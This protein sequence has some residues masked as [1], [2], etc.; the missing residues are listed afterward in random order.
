MTLDQYELCPCGSG[1]KIKFCCSRDLLHELD[2]LQTMIRG[3][4]RLAALEKID[5]LL[6][7]NPDRPS[8]LMLKVDLEL[9]LREADKARATLAKLLEVQPTNPSVV[10]TRSM[11]VLMLDRDIATAIHALQDSFELIDGTVTAR[12]Y[13]ALML[14]GTMLLSR[15]S[16]FAAKGH[17][18]F[19]LA[20]TD[21]KDERSA[22]S[23]M[24]LNQD[25]RIPLLLREPLSLEPC[26]A[27]VTWRIEFEKAMNEVGRGRW[28][29]GGKMLSA[30]ATRILDAPAILMNLGIVSGWLGDYDQASK[31]FRAYSQIREVPMERRVHA[32]ALAQELDPNSVPRVSLVQQT[33]ELE[34][35]DG[36]LEKCSSCNRLVS[37]P[38]DGN[39]SASDGG[40]P[41]KAIYRVLSKPALADGANDALDADP[42]LDQVPELLG[43]IIFFG[44]ETDQ[45]ARLII[46]ASRTHLDYITNLCQELVEKPLG[47]PTSDRP[48][49]GTP[50][51]ITELLG[52]WHL[53]KMKTYDRHQQLQRK[54]Q[55]K[56]VTERWPK[57]VM[58]FLD[59]KT[60]VDA[61][62]EAK[63]AVPLLGNLMTVGLTCDSLGVPFDVDAMRRQLNLPE[64]PPPS[65]QPGN[66]DRVPV[67]RFGE[68]DI[69]SLDDEQLLAAYRRSYALMVIKALR[70]TAREV[71]QRTSL[72]E[73][74]DKVEAYDILSDVAETT[75]ESLQYLSQAR[76]LATKEGES[77]AAWL[78]DEAELRLA[79][80]EID[81]FVELV[82][83][84][85]ARYIREPGVVQSLVEM[86]ARYGMVTPDGRV[87]LPQTEATAA[88]GSD[89]ASGLWTPDSDRAVASESKGESKLWI[90]GMD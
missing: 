48:M 35:L 85:Q 12:M 50:S 43:A 87:F 83:E 23:L 61:A 72:D 36:L 2:R 26:P 49:T 73:R 80:G 42:D 37:V 6:E 81:E 18:Q 45:P 5:S 15:Q 7:K 65:L 52:E 55:S 75:D 17:F 69:T 9:E 46:E 54:L 29:K 38:I 44:K 76:R 8:L 84:V 10:A 59:G 57:L 24:R 25:R 86:L 4:Q 67:H 66:L 11:V 1:K 78:I 33:F 74:V 41:P 71:I 53:P 32:A 34:S 58:P 3:E 28:R 13:E 68:L 89:S 82:K 62:G 64:L 16:F 56:A 60:P 21:G 39:V 20:L 47:A 22:S 31:S 14:L 90:P 77:P 88:V 51:P 30:M 27:N 63:Y 70:A 40:P 19:A 79:R